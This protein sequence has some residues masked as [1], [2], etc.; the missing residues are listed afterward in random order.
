[1]EYE[2]INEGYYSVVVSDWADNRQPVFWVG[3]NN[4]IPWVWTGNDHTVPHFRGA[5]WNSERL[6]LMHDRRPVAIF[7]RVGEQSF[8]ESIDQ[9]RRLLETEHG[10]LWLSDM[11]ELYRKYEANFVRE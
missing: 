9:G 6:C 5:V 4:G 3:I 7:S 10:R 2:K 1:M 8:L 11:L